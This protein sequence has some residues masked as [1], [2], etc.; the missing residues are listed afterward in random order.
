MRNFSSKK[1]RQLNDDL[2]ELI[3][4]HGL[5]EVLFAIED[6]VANYDS[7]KLEPLRKNLEDSV[8]EIEEI[9]INGDLN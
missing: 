4:K 2:I 9:T 8:L 3:E 1:E 7:D 5:S 6:I